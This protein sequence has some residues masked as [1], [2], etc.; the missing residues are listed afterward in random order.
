MDDQKKQIIDKLKQAT[1]ILVTVKS[2]PSIDQLAACI[3][4]T[5][6]L[7]ELGKHA[8][9]VF[10][11]TVPSVLEF[12]H[13]EKTLET[14]T[15]SLRDFI[16]ALDK[17]KA[18]KLRYKVEDKVVKIFITP[19]KTSISDAD[20]EFSQGDFN[21]DVVL[22]LGV[23]VQDDLDTAITEHGKILHDATVM[24]ITTDDGEKLGTVNWLGG[25][26]SSLSE[27]VAGIADQL[28]KKDILDNQIATALLTGIVS[29]T[30]RFSNSKTT[31]QTMSVSAKLLTAG[32]NQ[33]LVASKLAEPE[34]E[35]V[36]ERVDHDD[37]D[38]SNGDSPKPVPDEPPKSSDGMLSIDH[39]EEESMPEEEPELEK[40]EPA[41]EEKHDE[42]AAEEQHETKSIELPRAEAPENPPAGLPEDEQAAMDLLK[43]R[44]IQVDEHGSLQ[45]IE[46]EHRDF[47][48]DNDHP[49]IEQTVA[50]P[51]PEEN[52]AGA[53][54][55]L[56]KFALTPP[57]MG[58]TLTA[59]SRPEG[60]EPSTDPMTMGKDSKPQILSHE[61][62]GA[63]KDD[64]EQKPAEPASKS[65][66]KS[67]PKAEVRPAEEHAEP[68]PQ[69]EQ[70]PAKPDSLTTPTAGPEAASEP[71]IAPAFPMPTEAP[72]P[73]AATEPSQPAK[74][75]QDLEKEVHSAHVEAANA[76]S[77]PLP[78]P[79]ATPGDGSFPSP[80]DLA[81]PAS[82]AHP[83]L[84]AAL[85]ETRNMPVPESTSMPVPE[86][87]AATPGGQLQAQPLTAAEMA[88]P[89]TPVPKPTVPAQ[90]TTANVPEPEL[91]A[92][93][94][95]MPLPTLNM[96]APNTTS[97]TS[98]P[99]P[100]ASTA[101]PVPPP[102]VPPI[103]Q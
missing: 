44:Q 25:E 100:N 87:S 4:L 93:T 88:A 89:A 15:D 91:Q 21:V 50:T 31:P 68:R 80:A 17:S 38:D 36:P 10:S 42:P 55:D 69:T 71:L 12:L 73:T 54:F 98:S 90:P 70:K 57:S 81:A 86:P 103:N 9:A 24:S 52:P 39:T 96:P 20:L 32:A 29:E 1:N 83:A 77:A 66:K 5:L 3:G 13:P 47:L 48:G 78:E 33:E 7:N 11:G 51:D 61:H 59:N 84:Q 94:M 18:D 2:N 82:D 28:G 40:E 45:P 34:P 67:V 49:L 35:A 37:P 53:P 76:G 41:P 60:F 19:Y 58:G 6:I 46:T 92:Q 102:F 14:N 95:D 30:E 72:V 62:P 43:N 85:Q 16:I 65:D 64:V 27:M 74:T 8:T 26:V 23:H 63:S 99:A 79:V 56:S 75:L 22:A 97:A 101:P